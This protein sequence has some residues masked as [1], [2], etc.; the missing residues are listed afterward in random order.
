M[1]V[2]QRMLFV[3]KG[4]AHDGSAVNR[5]IRNVRFQYQ[6]SDLWY[7]LLPALYLLVPGSSVLKIAFFLILEW[8][9]EDSGSSPGGSIGELVSGVFV[10]GIAQVV[11]VRMAIATL[12][13]AQEI[14][15]WSGSIQ[16]GAL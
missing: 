14:R 4:W 12:K 6:C 1:H 15:V 8:V 11:D 3:D 7:C 9:W 16:G 10:I 2:T 5:Y 13:M